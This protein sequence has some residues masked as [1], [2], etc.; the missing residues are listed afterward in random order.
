MGHL[1]HFNTLKV[2]H[3]KTVC[4]WAR[5]Y[6][7]IFHLRLANVNVCPLPWQTLDDVLHVPCPPPHGLAC[8]STAIDI[9]VSP[10]GVVRA[11]LYVKV[12]T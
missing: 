7:G 2:G 3:H 6:G 4:R 1:K 11:G 8:L 9:Q 10:C 5:Q 12:L